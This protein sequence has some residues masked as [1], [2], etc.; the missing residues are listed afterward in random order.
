MN[1]AR[2]S[3]I[4]LV[5]ISA[6][7]FAVPVAA[8]V[9]TPTRQIS[10]DYAAA[11]KAIETK[12]YAGAVPLLQKAIVAEPKSADILN[13]LGFAYRNLGNLDQA[14]THYLNALAV[15]PKHRG[16]NEYL[17]ELY[18]MRGDLAKAEERLAVL[19]KACFFGCPEY[20]DLKK[21]IAAYKTKSG[22]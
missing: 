5:A 19:D 4:A 18:L 11:R 1:R 16:A 7:G 22:K 8:D 21:A 20:D 6:I 9:S 13:D 2:I 17:G 12:N 14:Q 15:D 10:P 3:A